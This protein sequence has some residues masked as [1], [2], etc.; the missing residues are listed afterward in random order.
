MRIFIYTLLVVVAILFA[1]VYIQFCFGE[2]ELD[3]NRLIPAII[4]VESGGNSNAVSKARA[5]GLMQITPIVLKEYNLS[6]DLISSNEITYLNK[7]NGKL[8]RLTY[9]QPQELTVPYLNKKIGTWYLRRLKDHYLKD[10]YTIERLLSAW[11]GGITR[12]RRLNYDCSK[13]PRET[14]NFTRKVLNLYRGKN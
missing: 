8:Q 6:Q 7:P 14:R 3:W 10:N 11:N 9:Y 4:S 12:L 13:M 2:E 1:C 5:I